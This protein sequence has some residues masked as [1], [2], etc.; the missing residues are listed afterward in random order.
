M[1]KAVSKSLFILLVNFFGLFF[2]P[3]S[4]GQDNNISIDL[5]QSYAAPIGEFVHYFQENGKELSA[6]NAFDIFHRQKYLESIINKT[7]KQ[8]LSFGIGEAP[9][10]MSI[11]INNSSNS[12]K[13]KI[14]EVANS[15]L[16][17]VDFYYFMDG[18]IINQKKLGDN[19]PFTNRENQSHYFE[20]AHT[21][22]PGVTEVLIRVETIDAII[23]PIYLLDEPQATQN[24]E[25][26]AYSYGIL[27]GG[28][29]SL[30]LY[31][32]ILF[33]SLRDSRYL[34]YSLYLTCFLAMNIGYSGHGFRWLWPTSTIWQMWC[35]S[36]LILCFN[37]SALAFANRFLNLK[38]NFP[39]IQKVLFFLY[40]IAG[41]IFSIA[42]LTSNNLFALYI[43]MT[44]SLI[45]PFVMV[46]LGAISLTKGDRSTT[47]FLLGSLFA[48]IGTGVTASAV[49]GLIPF[50][51][52]TYRAV[53]I[54]MFI[55]AVLLALALAEL[56]KETKEKKVF[57]EN[58]AMLDPLTGLGNR[59]AFY[60]DFL[61][62]WD[63][64][65]KNQSPMTCL[66]LDIDNFKFLNDNYGHA[67]GDEIIKSIA[68][69]IKQN[70]RGRD[71]ST[72]WGGDEFLIVLPNT[73]PHESIQVAERIRKTIEDLSFEHDQKVTASIGVA[74]FEGE[75]SIDN[76]INSADIQLY[77]A[78]K[79][80]RNQVCG[81]DT[82]NAAGEVAF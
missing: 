48:S 31:N 66:L 69:V 67:F 34:F 82:N 24:K 2:S 5:N 45:Y 16:D 80:G 33:V 35:G 40:A 13:Q 22:Q 51:Q 18:E 17:R 4:L 3:L 9:V 6:L 19:Q 37:F 42:A 71:I 1:K 12:P 74:H 11:K 25:I 60:E 62:I 70:A 65:G 78:K 15:W 47:Y 20:V 26:S 53:E 61:P 58:M 14:L 32:F 50:H 72:R 57:A 44:F 23:L 56:V 64:K 81:I 77:R 68:D 28:L 49:W 73:N 41:I 79:L 76:F 38:V 10:W 63:R 36:T 27:Y 30:L 52:V 29:L 46:G 7:D 59:R 75:D 8:V 21:F 55:D 54:G 39:T 43:S